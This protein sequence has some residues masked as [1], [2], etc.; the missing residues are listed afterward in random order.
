MIFLIFLVNCNNN[1]CNGG[2]CQMLQG[3]ISCTCPSNRI[4]VLCET[5]KSSVTAEVIGKNNYNNFR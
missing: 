4:G 1:P 2:S 5:V 3:K